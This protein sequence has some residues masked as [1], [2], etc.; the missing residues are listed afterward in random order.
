[1][2]EDY[3]KL[4]QGQLSGTGVDD[5]YT[6]AANV[7]IKEIRIVNY[8]TNKNWIKIH[9]VDENSSAG[10]SNLILPEI[11]LDNGGWLVEHGEITPTENDLIK[12][13]SD[14]AMTYTLYGVEV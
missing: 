6:A 7:I 11:T 14:G 12:A 4:A 13:E 3:Q 5:L 10:N 8:D 9:D 2:A 1:M